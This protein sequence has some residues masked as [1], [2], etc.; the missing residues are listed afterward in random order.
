MPV[1]TSYPGVYVEELSSL[2]LSITNGATAVPVFA[3]STTTEAP[4]N[5][6]PSRATTL[7]GVHRISS[8]LDFTRIVGAFD[9]DNMLHASL[10]TYFEN[11]G[12]YCYLVPV[13]KLTTEVPKLDD[14]TLLAAAGTDITAAAGTL[15]NV[16]SGL[17]AILDGPRTELTTTIEDLGYSANPF[18]AVYY[19]WLIADWS[20][21]AIPPS[22]AVCGAINS[23]DRDRGVWKAPANIALQGGVSPQFKVSDEIQGVYNEGLA[24]NMIRSFKGSGTTIW[25]ARTLD[26]GDEWRY[27]SVR[28]LFNT[29]ERDIKQSMNTAVFE[30]NTQSTW[31]KV[32]SAIDN[33]LHGIWQRGG[34]AGQKQNDA[35]FIQVGKDITMTED[36]IAQGKMI[37]KVGLAAVR[38]AEFIILQFTQD[39]GNS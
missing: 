20:T 37:V 16:G 14:V 25:G 1:T 24:V 36:D 33:Y 34:L 9:P 18:C 29:V 7:S 19:P 30:P 12:G 38:P 15:C 4:E 17:F 11:G 39:V 13:D 28:R 23:A 32:R 2:S 35:Y 26:D 27:I 8:W 5:T 21:K 31:E 3:Y 6:P 22:G 10:R